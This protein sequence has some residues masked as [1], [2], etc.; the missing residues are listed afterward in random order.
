MLFPQRVF[1]KI[2]NALESY[3]G[4]NAS[5]STPGGEE[6]WK[7]KPRYCFHIDPTASQGT[8]SATSYP[9]PLDS[10]E[11]RTNL[12]SKEIIGSVSYIISCLNNTD[13]R[14]LAE[15]E[16][17]QWLSHIC[18][19][20][21]YVACL[22]FHSELSYILHE[23]STRIYA[24]GSR[25]RKSTFVGMHTSSNSAQ[26][27]QECLVA[28]AKCLS[29]LV[30]NT[31]TRLG[32]GMQLYLRP[33]VELVAWYADHAW[34]YQS[35]GGL[36]LSG[37]GKGQLSRTEM[38][39]V[40]LLP[41]LYSAVTHL[42]AAHPEQAVAVVSEYGH[43]LLRLAK[44]NYL[45]SASDPQLRDALTEYFGAH[46]LVAETSGK[47]YGLPEGDVG[48][49]VT[50]S[51]GDDDKNKVVLGAT[52]DMKAIDSLL[53]IVG[54]EKVWE[55]LFAN[56]EQQDAKSKPYQRNRFRTQ[57]KKRDKVM[58]AEGGG[59]WTLLNKRQRRYLELV[60]RLLRLSQRLHLAEAEALGDGSSDAI[61]DLKLEAEEMMLQKSDIENGE[62][63]V[64]TGT[65]SSNV[66]LNKKLA[67]DEAL[68]E[69]PFVSLVCQHLY[70][71]NPK[72]TNAA[73][74][75]DINDTSMTQSA[76]NT[77]QVHT[78]LGAESSGIKDKTTTSFEQSLLKS[79]PLLRALIANYAA[80][81][82]PPGPPTTAILQ[83][84]CSS[85]EAYPRGEC[86]SSS[87]RQNW[88]TTL[89]ENTYPGGASARVRERHGSS[90]ADAASVVYLLGTTLESCGGSG[91]DNDV[92][93]W[94]LVALL[95]MADS[96]AIISAREG[97]P[98]QSLEALRLAWK[99][100]WKTLLRY[101]LR[102]SSYTAGAY[103]NNCGELVLQ[104]LT[105]VIRYQCMNKQEEGQ[106]LA[107][108]GSHFI[109]TLKLPIFAKPTSIL[110]GAC[111]EL[112]TALMQYTEIPVN[113]QIPMSLSDISNVSDETRDSRW[114]VS[115][116]LN[117]IENSL[118]DNIGAI[119]QRSFLPFAATCLA[120]LLSDGG[121]VGI[122]STYE[123]DSL[124]RFSVTEDTDYAVIK[125]PDLDV[126]SYDAAINT[127]HD[128][129]WRKILVPY[130][131]PS[132][133]SLRLEQ[134]IMHGRG[135]LLNQFSD[136]NQEREKLSASRHI[137]IDSS[138]SVH[139]H[140]ILGD[141]AFD[142]IKTLFDEIHFGILYGSDNEDES[143]GE[144][145]TSKQRKNTSDTPR[146]TGCLSLLISIVLSS[147][148]TIKDI[149][150]CI[151]DIAPETIVR[152]FDHLTEVLDTLVLQPADVLSVINHVDGIVRVLAH[153][154]AT[155]IVTSKILSLINDQL[156]AIFATCTG[157]LRNYR[158]FMYTSSNTPPT[159]RTT[160]HNRRPIYESDDDLFETT[161]KS[162]QRLQNQFSDDSDGFM[163]DAE[164]A[165]PVRVGIRAPP[166]RSAP[167][168]KRQR[169]E[170]ISNKV[171]RDVSHASKSIDC[172]GAW[173]CASLMI[174]L[175]P[176]IECLEIITGHLVWPEDYDS[177]NGYAPVSKDCDP[178]D[179]LVCAALFCKRT[180]ILREHLLRSNPA[181]NN[182]ND[183]QSAIVLCIEVILQ[184]R[185]HLPPSSKYFMHGLGF[186]SKL[187][188]FGDRT[189]TCPPIS[190]DES[191]FIINALYP[192]GISQD[193][194]DYRQM[195]QLRKVFKVRHQYRVEQLQTSIGIFLRAKDSV[196]S[197]L[198]S[199]FSDYFI[200]VTARDEWFF[201]CRMN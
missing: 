175:N 54:D 126:L 8:Y 188:E 49:L 28:C 115:F 152:V 18:A 22:P 87:A 177:E 38:D 19:R 53:Q 94:T 185:R 142:K 102:Y 150:E 6:D 4:Y 189:E 50:E 146:I 109:Q 3:N 68:A 92:Q 124:T 179:A 197:A 10:R 82:H 85:A 198:D 153:L 12:S 148:V 180:V 41:Q 70:K 199:I 127:V 33:I 144:N 119:V 44:K 84:V 101:D 43:V 168:P 42:L 73:T 25:Q 74:H 178:Y 9:Q 2:D 23:I 40:S 5:V 166:K 137:N 131:H 172:Q 83:L 95:K 116:C 121:I 196:H 89:D 110:T 29:G 134:R 17:M 190:A 181:V 130:I 113:T 105:Q 145:A 161:R 75:Q 165:A 46:L 11:N 193:N 76:M 139:K 141:M 59:K 13:C 159:H 35:G 1:L 171:R 156:K 140:H 122:A 78:Q 114:L 64:D 62:I 93:V 96:S 15:V 21:D 174:L 191:K 157:M 81:A 200:K 147:R 135:A 47:L 163:D 97:V 160:T 79:C 107:S 86:W 138:P 136:A 52:L 72:L 111:F 184:A 123:L 104:L 149:S 129:L 66:A 32:M 24:E 57:K 194:E 117:F 39:I 71:S 88:S 61:E 151:I 45:K 69:T 65:A 167:P 90:P 155:S 103:T 27:R 186:L 106:T 164:V 26:V 183:G 176:S 192:E 120:S 36:L 133:C 162:T 132:D 16:L 182:K 34:T 158:H 112:V 48:P 118:G 67:T 201:S 91:G 108:D 30:Y 37:T 100:V 58:S 14:D 195:R 128:I 143:E 187:I 56:V 98:V 173:S 7:H 169:T 31:T 77:T 154:E 99:Y 80:S 20:V 60:A 55:S 125:R 170:K 51:S 63:G